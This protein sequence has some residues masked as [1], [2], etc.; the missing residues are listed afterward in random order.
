ASRCSCVLRKARRED[1][2]LGCGGPA[3]TVDIFNLCPNVKCLTMRTASKDD[4]SVVEGVLTQCDKHRFL[5]C[6]VIYPKD[7]DAKH[8]E[9]VAELVEVFLAKLDCT[10]FPAL[11]EIQQLLFVW[12]RSGPLLADSPWVKL[13]EKFRAQNIHLVD[14]YGSRLRPR[15]AFVPGS[16]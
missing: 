12:L 11:R 13:A 15:R 3:F 6:I 2:G 10:A 5:E 4:V 16:G 8:S 9:L 7:L 14:M 1:L